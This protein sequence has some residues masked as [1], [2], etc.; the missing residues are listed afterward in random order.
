M[1]RPEDRLELVLA[2]T[3]E[4]S[5]RAA[6]EKTLRD[7][8]FDHP[9][10]RM[11]VRN[12]DGS[13]RIVEYDWFPQEWRAYWRANIGLDLDPA[14]RLMRGRVTPVIWSEID[15]TNDAP[16]IAPRFALGLG[17]GATVPVHGPSGTISSIEM[18]MNPGVKDGN[19]F[20]RDRSGDLMLLAGV[21]HEAASRI[22]APG[23]ATL[24]TKEGAAITVTVAAGPKRSLKEKE[25]AVLI[26]ISQ[27][28]KYVVIADEM[29][30]S[31]HS[32]DQYARSLRGLWGATTNS[33]M[34][35]RAIAAKTIPIP[36][37]RTRDL[38]KD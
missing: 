20:I 33:E 8:G 32:V 14:I 16:L 38:F 31:S 10:F 22:Y 34:V 4:V 27:G 21:I 18:G 1:S 7:V 17:Q 15:A 11:F 36:L 19:E 35:A 37:G 29:K 26:G 30:I 9:L 13:V 12:A 6:V 24:A 25:L 28:K 2:A 3:D 5:L 23:T